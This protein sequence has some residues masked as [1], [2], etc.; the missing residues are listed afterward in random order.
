M[1]VLEILAYPNPFLRK[2]A[3]KVTQFDDSLKHNKV[4][5]YAILAWQNS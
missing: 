3:Q 2:V 1:A 4:K 5:I